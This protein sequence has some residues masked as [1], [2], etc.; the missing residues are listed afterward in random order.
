MVS[1]AV[2]SCALQDKTLKCYDKKMVLRSA[3]SFLL[4]AVC[5]AALSQ[6]SGQT[7]PSGPHIFH[8]SALGITY[9][10]PERFTPAQL[11]PAKA[12]AKPNCAQSTL[13]GSSA[14]PV[15][16]SAFVLSSIGNVCPTVLHGA[17]SNLDAFTREQVLRQ[18]KQ[19]GDPV[20]TQDPT[21]YTIDGHPAAITIASV[22]HTAAADTAGNS[23]IIPPQMTYAAKACVL[24]EVPEKHSKASLA[25]QTTHIVCF[26]FTTQ[27][28]DLLPLMLAFTVQFDGHGP[29]PIVPGSVLR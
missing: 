11:A 4:L 21:H 14:S 19:Y 23:N 15:G 25:D 13:T 8:D 5:A 10:Y 26:D 29:Q 20:I 7:A 2:A 9:F 17:A 27:Q 1:V 28:R 18:L 22:K 6:T 16:T 24:G 3:A 12:E